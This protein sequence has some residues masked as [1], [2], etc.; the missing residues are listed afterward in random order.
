MGEVF[1]GASSIIW[2]GTRNGIDGDQLYRAVELD[3][4]IVVKLDYDRNHAVQA[5]FVVNERY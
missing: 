5:E 3:V 2:I 1:F 4:K